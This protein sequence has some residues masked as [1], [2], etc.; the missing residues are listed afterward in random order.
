MAKT[1][2]KPGSMGG[3][4][5][6]RLDAG[7]ALFADEDLRLD[8]GLHPEAHS[9]GAGLGILLLGVGA[10]GE[11]LGWRAGTQRQGLRAAAG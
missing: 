6:I 1:L 5:R 10:G 11:F 4:R 8:A 2:Q 3:P 9:R 7:K